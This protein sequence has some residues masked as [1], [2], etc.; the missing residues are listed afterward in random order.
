MEHVLLVRVNHPYLPHCL[1]NA[2]LNSLLNI[3]LNDEPFVAHAKIGKFERNLDMGLLRKDHLASLRLLH[4]LLLVHF[5][6][7]K[8]FFTIGHDKGHQLLLAIVRQ[9]FL[10]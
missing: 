9:V 1:E 10:I 4:V 6:V 8:Q 7:D 5:L 2:I 3:L